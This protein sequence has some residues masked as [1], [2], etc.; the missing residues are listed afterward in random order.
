MARLTK[1]DMQALAEMNQCE[2]F[3]ELDRVYMTDPKSPLHHDNRCKAH[4]CDDTCRGDATSNG[5][6]LIGGE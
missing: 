5:H 3:K 2:R 1:N 4:H 6:C